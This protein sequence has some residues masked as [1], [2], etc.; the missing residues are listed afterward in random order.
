MVDEI[1]SEDEP[2][3]VYDL[4]LEEDVSPDTGAIMAEAVAAVS[5]VEAK[6]RYDEDEGGDEAAAARA[7]VE[8]LEI[9]IA[10]LRERTLR[11]MADY[12]N[13]RR[14][15]ARDQEE[16]TKLAIMAPLRDFVGVLDN[17]ERAL[18]ATGS[19]EDLKQGVELIRRQMFDIVARQGVEPVESVG[20]R[21]DPAIHDAVHRVEDPSVA[22]PTVTMEMQRGYRYRE[23]L[24]R[25]AMVQVA[26]PPAAADGDDGSEVGEH[27]PA[28][29]DPPAS[30]G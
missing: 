2:E 22:A 6:R 8:E 7:R 15:A 29:E 12:E 1:P 3:G 27:L 30:N 26:V 23:R 28:D 5:A 18:D 20:Q 24:L 16:S 14:R 25:P 19:S 4:D 9:E 10:E 21:F 17:L 13:F 11:T